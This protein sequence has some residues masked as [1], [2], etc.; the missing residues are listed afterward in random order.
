M[1]KRFEQQMSLGQVLISEVKI[2][3]RYRYAEAKLLRALQELFLTPAY[4]ERIFQILEE[5]LLKGKNKTGRKGMDLWVLFVLAQTRLCLGVSYDTLFYMANND[6]TLRQIMGI[7]Y[8]DQFTSPI[9]IDYQTIIDNVTLL[10]DHTLIKINDIIVEMGHTVLKKE[11]MEPLN[12]KTDSFVVESNVHFPTDY[13]LLY[14][15]GRK[16]LDMI[17]KLLEYETGIAGWRKI[18]YWYRTLKNQMRALW[19]SLK[20]GGK[21]KEERVKHNAIQYITTAQLLVEKIERERLNL[22]LETETQLSIHYQLD[23]YL[24]MLKKHID[25]VERRLIKGEEIPHH[26]KIFSI[27]EPYT[28]WINKG[29]QHPEVELGKN[30]QITTDQFH[31]IIDYRVMEKES[32]KATVISLAD[33]ILKKWNVQS[34]SFDKGYYTK[35]N[36]E[37]LEL[38]INELVMPKKGKLSAEE[39]KVESSCRFVKLRHK[40]SAI[41]SNINE[42]ENRGLGR[43]PDRGYAHFKLYVSLGITAYNLHKI[44]NELLRRDKEKLERLNKAA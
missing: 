2:S 7:E 30:L 38:F 8:F 43:C 17:S 3:T 31:L 12:L 9:E 19:Q 21:N 24:T 32:D 10:D 6:K 25:L 37:L 42:L 15:S 29:K 27:F 20:N 33:R 5:K 34:W 22:P 16:S 36:K 39:H 13:N 18:N 4:N 1:R 14:D 26:E 28:E 41:E 23:Y 44:G 40:H 11:E 35:E